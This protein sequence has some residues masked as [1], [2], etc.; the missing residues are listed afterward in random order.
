MAWEQMDD[1]E[2]L[3]HTLRSIRRVRTNGESEDEDRL[4]SV[5]ALHGHHQVEFKTDTLKQLV[6]RGREYERTRLARRTPTRAKE[7][8]E[9]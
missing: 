3:E 8:E 4:I 5:V 1:W 9:E 6:D 7:K 2:W